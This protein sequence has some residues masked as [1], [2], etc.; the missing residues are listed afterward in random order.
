MKVHAA[1]TG[2]AVES[3]HLHEHPSEEFWLIN[4][5]NEELSDTLPVKS[6]PAIQVSA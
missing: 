6:A 4:Y 5:D 3:I 1:K 2:E